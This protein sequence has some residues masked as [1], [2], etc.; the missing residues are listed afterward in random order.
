MAIPTDLK[1]IHKLTRC[2][3]ALSLFISR[4]GE[5]AL[6]LYR[7]LR[8]TEH[9]E[10]TDTATAGLEE[11]NALLASNPILAAPN[12][13]EPMLLYISATHQLVSAVLVVEREQDG[14]KFPL[15]KPV[16][17]VSTVLTPCKSQ[18]PHYQKIAYAVFRASR[19]LRH[20]FQESSITVASEV[21]L[22]DIINNC[23]ATGQIAKWAIELLPFDITYKPRRA[24]KS[25]V[26]ADFVAE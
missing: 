1:Q 21:P 14:H 3:A 2:V 9:F 18:Y 16:Y 17:Y 25:Q 7:I 23:G 19:K 13:G 5:K 15:Q 10:W 11:I 4:L 8:C 24:I 26:P 20:Y 12:V 6:P 22:N